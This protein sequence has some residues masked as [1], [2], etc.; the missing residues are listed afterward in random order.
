MSGKPMS[1]EEFRAASESAEP[2]GEAVRQQLAFFRDGA[3]AEELLQPRAL[4]GMGG[5]AEW[6][7]S[8]VPVTR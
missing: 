6:P 4:S 5:W 1:F 7:Q 3:Q 2:L 8:A